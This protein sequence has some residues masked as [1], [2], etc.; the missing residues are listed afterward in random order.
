M[1]KD[2]RPRN[3]LQVIDGSQ[4]LRKNILVGGKL[5]NPMF[6]KS[7]KVYLQYDCRKDRYNR[8]I[9]EVIFWKIRNCGENLVKKEI[10]EGKDLA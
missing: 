3:I 7:G 8:M 1:I 9:A 4:E 2:Q 6:G 10:V 5:Q